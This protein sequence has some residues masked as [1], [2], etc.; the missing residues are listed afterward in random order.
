MTCKDC[1][2]SWIVDLYHDCP[3]C[4]PKKEQ[5]EEKLY[6]PREDCRKCAWTWL[7]WYWDPCI[8]RY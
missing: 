7:D 4:F 8:C 5:K 1:H 2:G 3:T 6:A